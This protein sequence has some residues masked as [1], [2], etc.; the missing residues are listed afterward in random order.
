MNKQTHA[1]THA[2]IQAVQPWRSQLSALVPSSPPHNHAKAPSYQLLLDWAYGPLSLDFAMRSCGDCR[3]PVSRLS[4]QP[5]AERSGPAAVPLR[6]PSRQAGHDSAHANALR[7]PHGR[8]ALVLFAVNCL[9]ESFVVLV[10]QFGAEPRQ[11]GSDRI[12]PGGDRVRAQGL[13]TIHLHLGQQVQQKVG[14]CC[15]SS[16]FGSIVAAA[17]HSVWSSRTHTVAQCERS[18]FRSTGSTWPRVRS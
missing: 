5:G 17:C 4:Q 12:G 6:G 14:A 16:F 10:V 8:S 7:G 15:L 11:P 9:A 1:Y 3:L 2:H 18:A 13:A